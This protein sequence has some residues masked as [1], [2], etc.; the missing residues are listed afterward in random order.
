MFINL[1]NTL[2]LLASIFV[3]LMRT[4]FGTI[5]YGC[6]NY[7]K[8]NISRVIEASK[9]QDYLQKNVTENINK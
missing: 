2:V 5:N 6:R 1:I 7:Y 3:C 4:K 8:F 9:L